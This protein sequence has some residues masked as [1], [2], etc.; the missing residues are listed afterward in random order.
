[1]GKLRMQ[2]IKSIDMEIKRVSF[3]PKDKEEDLDI[4]RDLKL[5]FLR[6]KERVLKELRKQEEDLKTAIQQIY[7]RLGGLQNCTESP[8]QFR[9]SPVSLKLNT[10]SLASPKFDG[11][12]SPISKYLDALNKHAPDVIGGEGKNLR[13]SDAAAIIQESFTPQIKERMSKF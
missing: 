11:V 4:V 3:R 13:R 9:S 8:I 2:S 6:F 5:E 12:Q 10:L 7:D 1:M